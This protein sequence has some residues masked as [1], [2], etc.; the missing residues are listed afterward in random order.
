MNKGQLIA[1]WIGIVIAIG[2]IVFPPWRWE[3][4][5]ENALADRTDKV[6][7]FGPSSYAPIF[8]PPEPPK[9]SG[10]GID[11]GRLSIQLAGVALVTA[12]AIV[13]LKKR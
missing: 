8:M 10:I 12:G 4:N 2:M 9:R 1:M 6:R 5:L 13:T 11:W 3:L 7:S